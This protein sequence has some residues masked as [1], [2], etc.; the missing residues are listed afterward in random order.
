MHVGYL[1]YTNVFT[2]IIFYITLLRDTFY[3]RILP[4]VMTL[5]CGLLVHVYIAC[6]R[7]YI[8]IYLIDMQ[9][10][11]APDE[12]VVV[13]DKLTFD[14][15]ML[16]SLELLLVDSIDIHQLQGRSSLPGQIHALEIRRSLGSLKV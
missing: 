12:M 10:S 9:I 16:H 3:H 7:L 4:E 6:T 14:L 13:A 8:C 2:H 1:I 5:T 11:P 15:S